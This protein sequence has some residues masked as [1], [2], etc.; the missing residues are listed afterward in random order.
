MLNKLFN[1]TVILI[2]AVFILYGCD[3]P[4]KRAEQKPVDNY[5]NPELIGHWNND[6]GCAIAFVKDGDHYLIT[7]FTDGKNHTF[8][9]LI[10]A[11]DKNGIMTQFKAKDSRVNFS[12]SF[13]E[14]MLVV[15]NYCAAA[16]HKVSY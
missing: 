3:I 4:A 9:N 15:N 11:S 6:Q 16:L 7:N 5:Y 14:G 2:L 13:A 1:K 10:L 8:S 12:G